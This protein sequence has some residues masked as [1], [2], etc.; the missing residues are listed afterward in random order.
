LYLSASKARSQAGGNVF[1]GSKPS[2]QPEVGNGAILNTATIMHNALASAVKAERGALFNNTKTAVALRNTLEE[3][4]HKQPPTPLQVKN[5]MAVGFDNNQLKQ[6]R[7]KSMEMR[8][9]W[10]QDR[11]AQKQFH[12]YL[13]RCFV[14]PKS[15][16]LL[17]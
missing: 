14:Y 5:S 2:N 7:S 10:I 17:S 1:L 16:L 3:M 4:G 13:L 11:V 9:Y 8:F 15:K 6:Q 12:V